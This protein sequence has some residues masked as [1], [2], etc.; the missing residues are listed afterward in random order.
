[1]LRGLLRFVDGHKLALGKR[2]IVFLLRIE[3]M[4]RKMRGV[5]FGFGFNLWLCHLLL[6]LVIWFIILGN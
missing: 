6:N 4:S 5:C 3:I 2:R 1:M